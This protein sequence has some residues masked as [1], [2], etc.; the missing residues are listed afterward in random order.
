MHTEDVD[1]CLGL[2]QT[3]IRK[4]G[5]LKAAVSA[6]IHT[7]T[8]WSEEVSDKSLW[9]KLRLR[10]CELSEGKIFLEVERARLL[11]SLANYRMQSDDVD[12]AAKLLQDVPVETFGAIEKLEQAEFI[13]EQLRLVMLNGDWI[14]AQ[15]VSRKISPK[16]LE[17]DDMKDVKYR[18]YSQMVQYHTHEQDYK[19][20]CSCYE[21]LLETEKITSSEALTLS[22][23][24]ENVIFL[25]LCH[26]SDEQR[27]A[28]E[29]LQSNYRKLLKKSPFVR[30]LIHD[31]LGHNVLAW[32]LPDEI[33][34][35]RIFSDDFAPNAEARRALLRRRMVQ[36]NIYVFANFY[37]RVTLERL[38]TVMNIPKLEVEREVCDLVSSH[39]LRAKIDRPLD[40]VTF[41][42]DE[43]TLEAWAQA[44][45]RSV[46]LV[47]DACHLIDKER[48]IHAANLK[49]KQLLAQVK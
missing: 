15:I 34:H 33:Q 45:G 12:G 42:R 25:L 39:G 49:K 6:M 9:Y 36:H 7:A 35:L 46:D 22:T 29:S 8:Q 11:L 26:R 16:V 48:V 28:L 14:R 5:Q 4:R 23:V 18:F 17:T 30:I 27:A 47:D 24:E 37:S 31:V 3:L 44:V 32:P 41:Q 1:Y 13:L 20:V 38:A 21:K 40:E 19:E 2:L 43:H 10:L